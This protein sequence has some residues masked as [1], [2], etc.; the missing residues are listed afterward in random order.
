MSFD[1]KVDDTQVR[2]KLDSIARGIKDFSKPLNEAADVMLE[3]Y[4]N[5]VF[6]DQGSLGEKWKPLSAATLL[7]RKKRTGHYKKAPKTTDKTLIW[8]GAMQSSFFKTVNN[9][10]LVISNNTDYF[11]YH[12]SRGGRTPQRRMLYLNKDIITLVFDKVAKHT[13]QL[14]G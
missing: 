8:T 1:F 7:A 9:V 12:Q 10:K 6:N 3:I 4:G 2:K 13:K 5:K 14:I 11:K